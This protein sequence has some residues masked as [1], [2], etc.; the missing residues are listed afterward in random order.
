MIDSRTTNFTHFDL[1]LA[2]DSFFFDIF[3]WVGVPLQRLKHSTSGHNTKIALRPRH[4]HRVSDDNDK[5]SG[6]VSRS[7][8]LSDLVLFRFF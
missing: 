4:R 1:L 3:L 8:H 5:A 6:G 7:G 2:A